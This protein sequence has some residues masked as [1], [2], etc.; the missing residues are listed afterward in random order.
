MF[1]GIIYSYYLW[2]MFRGKIAAVSYLNTIPFIYGIEHANKLQA[3]LL[4]CLP[5]HCAELFKSGEVEIALVPVGTLYDLEDYKIITSFCI[6]ASADVRT[7]TIMSNSPIEDVKTLWLDSHSRTSALL[8]KILCE[9]YWNV[10]PDYKYLEDYS[11]L[12]C[13]NP[14]EA[15]L[16]IGDKVFAQERKFKYSYDLAKEWIKN[17]QLPFV[18]AVWVAKESCPIEIV[19]QLNDSLKYGVE[20]IQNAID[21]FN[22]NTE[23]YEYQYLTEN[24][25]FV[26]DQDKKKAL[27]LFCKKGLKF[28]KFINP[29]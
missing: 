2:M 19:E 5:S 14:N 6:G 25:D 15:F 1:L 3:S 28:K 26:F 13:P 29:G 22:C 21:Y 4:P 16:L 10:S 12:D 27:E 8:A 24:I 23:G 9:E 18:F 7:V 11:I 17:T 20:N